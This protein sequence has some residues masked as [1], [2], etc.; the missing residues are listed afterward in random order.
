MSAPEAHRAI[1][2]IWH[3]ESSRLIAALAV[4][5]TVVYVAIVVGIG[6][7]VGSR[8]DPILS[9]AAAAIVALAFQPAEVQFLFAAPLSR[10]ALLCYKIARGQLPLFVSALIWVVLM[11]RWGLTLAAPMRFATAVMAL[12][13]SRRLVTPVASR[14]PSKSST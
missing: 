11:Q 3:I 10:R 1:D 4:F 5:I 14:S 6:A 9:A 8:A 7:I 12:T 2:A 13:S